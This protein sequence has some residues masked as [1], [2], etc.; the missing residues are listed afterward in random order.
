[1][2]EALSRTC[3]FGFATRN[4][5]AGWQPGSGHR[6]AGLEDLGHHPTAREGAIVGALNAAAHLCTFPIGP[7]QSILDLAQRLTRV[8]GTGRVFSGLRVE[9]LAMRKQGLL[10]WLIAWIAVFAVLFASAAPAL[11]HGVVGVEDATWSQI[12]TAGGSKWVQ[13]GVEGSAPSPADGHDQAHCPWCSVHVLSLAL[14]TAGLSPIPVPELT[15]TLAGAVNCRSQLA[16][17]V[18]RT[19]AARPSGEHVVA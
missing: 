7:N 5:R 2:S 12:C 3:R 15:R 4:S 11:S 13:N 6:L 17:G 9:F 14:P 19:A 18:V 1:M 10:A 8:P 16:Q